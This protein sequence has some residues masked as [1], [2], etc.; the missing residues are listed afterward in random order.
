[1]LT[2]KQH[3]LDFSPVMKVSFQ[4]TKRG[5]FYTRYFIEVLAYVVI[6]RHF[7]LKLI[8]WRLSLSKSSYPLNFIDSCIKSFL[9]KLYTPKV[10]V[11]NVPKRNVFVKLP[12]LGSTSFQIRK[13][14][15]KLFSD[16]LTSCNL[17]IVFTSPVRVKSFFTFKDKLPKMLLSGLVY[18]YDGCIRPY[19][20]KKGKEWQQYANTDPRTPLMLQQLYILWR[21][22]HLEQG[23]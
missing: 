1:M 16:K 6:S 3:L 23:K 2:E 22:F 18:K 20:W 11:P 13:K 19:Y 8:I 5:D 21:P 10:V 4:R 15:Q 7:I 14:L 12:F 17:K 9:N